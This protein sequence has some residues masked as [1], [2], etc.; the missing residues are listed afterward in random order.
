MYTDRFGRFSMR[1]YRNWKRSDL[2]GKNT[3]LDLT[4]EDWSELDLGTINTIAN[5]GKSS[6][7]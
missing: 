3:T 1:Y 2:E 4:G 7:E 5:L 6:L